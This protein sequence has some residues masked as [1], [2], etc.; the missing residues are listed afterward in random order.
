AILPAV[1]CFASTLSVCVPFVGV[2]PPRTG[3]KVHE[4]GRATRRRVATRSVSMRCCDLFLVVRPRRFW[5]AKVRRGACSKVYVG[6]HVPRNGVSRG[7]YKECAR[8]VSSGLL[9][10]VCSI[11][12]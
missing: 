9:G 4:T 7:S 8:V 11:R 12:N 6:G 2:C 3:Q 5:K 10:A 1:L